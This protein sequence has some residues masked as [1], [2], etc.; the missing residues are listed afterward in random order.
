MKQLFK[1]NQDLEPQI[2]IAGRFPHDE[3]NFERN[4]KLPFHAIHLYQYEGE[5]SINDHLFKFGTGDLTITPQ[6]SLSSYHLIEKGYH[7][8]VHFKFPKSKKQKNLQLPLCFQLGERHQR[9]HELFLEIITNLASSE[10][11]EVEKSIAKKNLQLILLQLYK[12]QTVQTDSEMNSRVDN[13]VEQ[14]VEWILHHIDKPFLISE[15]THEIGYS[16]NYLSNQF[17]K[18]HGFTIN[19]FIL[20]KRIE[21]AKYLLQTTNLSI[22][23]IGVQ[24]GLPDPHHFNKQFRLHTGLSPRKWREQYLKK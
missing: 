15:L 5:V 13:A 16:Q 23:L 20:Q 24:S 11:L 22:K 7:Y 17:K 12:F 18:R 14:S 21:R 9:I 3:T 19:S 2:L 1:W 8:C 10:P 4:H 6:D